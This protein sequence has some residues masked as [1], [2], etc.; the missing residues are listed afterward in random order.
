MYI[1]PL[2]TLDDI[3]SKRVAAFTVCCY[4]VTCEEDMRLLPHPAASM[5]TQSGSGGIAIASYCLI[6]DAQ[7]MAV[8][9]AT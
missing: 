6:P 2:R 1:S 7:V 3:H 9:I 4:G 8:Y 5:A